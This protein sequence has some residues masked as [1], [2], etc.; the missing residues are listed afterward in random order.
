MPA[1]LTPQYHDAE[2]RFKDASDDSARI[3]ALEEMLRVIP[4]HKGTEKM[5]AELKRRLA[6][7]RKQFSKK[8]A[9]PSKKPFY[10]VDREGAGQVLI[11]GPP[12]SGKS[13]IVSNLTH[14]EPE[15]ADYPFTTRAPVPGMMRFEDVQ[16]QLVDTVP[17]APQ[18]LEPWQLAVMRVADAV[19]LIF[20]V[21]D[22]DLLAQ[23]E[24]VLETMKEGHIGLGRTSQPPIVILGNK[25]D[26]EGGMEDFAAWTELFSDEIDAVPFSALSEGDLGEFKRLCFDLLGVVRV[27]TKAPGGRESASSDPFVL[28]KGSTVMDAA[29]SVHK[30]LAQRFKFARVWNDEKPHGLMVERTYE[31]KD[32]DLV[33]IHV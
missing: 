25:V 27:Y 3:E 23:T 13:Q 30:D 20:D 28:K 21:S 9:G 18:L 29:R 11:C 8:G 26:R 24:F 5:Q 31:M 17:L 16:I 1:N 6:K 14:A 33:E 12:N 32:G 2:Q 10:Q 7:L 22:P 4:K 19:F 15:V